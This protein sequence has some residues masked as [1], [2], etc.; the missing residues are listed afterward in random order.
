MPANGH[1]ARTTT[2]CVWQLRVSAGSDPIDGKRRVVTETFRG[3]KRAATTRLTELDRE[4]K[5]SSACGQTT[6]R[7]TIAAW[8]ANT[9]HAASTTGNYDLAIATISSHL[10]KTPIEK[11]RA[12]TLNDL[13]R[14]VVDEHGIG[15]SRLVHAVISGA[16]TY[17]WRQEWVETNVARRVSPPA[18][19]RR[20]ASAPTPAEVRKLIALVEQ[21]P[22][23]YAWL[24]VSAMVGGRRSETLALRW[25]D[26][27]LERGQRSI[28]KAL[29]PV[30]RGIKVTK[31]DN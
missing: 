12:A 21:R 30:A 17:A 22:E 19:P 8:R 31:T 28:T 16:L 11:I 26:V 5:R 4:A 25:S 10:M 1:H 20:R 24:L 13:Y 23:T 2:R 9:A 14:C 29:D 6:L 7:A 18:Q 27:D 15:R 3:S